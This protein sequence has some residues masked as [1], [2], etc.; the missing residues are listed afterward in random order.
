[1]EDDAELYEDRKMCPRSKCCEM[2]WVVCEQCGGDG[3]FGHDCGE[4][5]CCCRYPQ[6][7]LECDACDGKGG[8]WYCTC[9]DNGKHKTSLLTSISSA[10]KEVGILEGGL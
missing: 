8:Y 3:V 10:P 6:D 7:N 9:D 1:M 2:D 5:T 4:D